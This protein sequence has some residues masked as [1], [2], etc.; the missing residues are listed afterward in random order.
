[1]RA[2]KRD[3]AQH[4][5]EVAPAREIPEDAVEER[6]PLGLSGFRRDEILADLDE[7]ELPIGKARIAR[8]GKDVTLIAWSIGMTY[9]L[10]AAEE[11]AG[12]GA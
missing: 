8:P 5:H 9:A 7:F 4:R 10:K 2:V 12:E 3:L 6:G 1:M 11:L